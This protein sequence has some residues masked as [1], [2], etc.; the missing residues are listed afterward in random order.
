MAYV[1]ATDPKAK[2]PI[3]HL[4]G[5]ERIVQAGPEQSRRVNGYGGYKVLAK[6]GNVRLVFYWSH[7][8]CNFYGIATPGPA[9]IA[10]EALTRIAA[11]PARGRDPW[12]L[13]QGAA[14]GSPERSQPLLV[15]L[16]PWLRAEPELTSQKTKLAA[17]IRYVLSRWEGLCMFLDN[18]RDRHQLSSHGQSVRSR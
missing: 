7:V 17:A 8:G 15:A 16:E 18:G 11:L 12:S 9:P 3:A 5:F 4:S 6:Q 14:P 13:R 2:R 10:A 1:Y